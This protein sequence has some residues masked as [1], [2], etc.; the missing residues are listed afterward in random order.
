[1]QLPTEE[2]ESLRDPILVEESE[3]YV[4]IIRLNRP[5]KKNALSNDLVEA[6]V[7][8]VESAREDEAVRV[9][10][11]TGAGDTFFADADPKPR[12]DSG[13][14]EKRTNTD[15]TID[16]SVRLVAG[17]LFLARSPSLPVST[18][19]PLA[20]GE[21]WLCVAICVSL[22]PTLIFILDTLALEPRWIVA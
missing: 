2:Y 6:I 22:A 17:I 3:D 7:W 16:I 10:G 12:K 11:I 14:S 19:L 21:H 15:T 13:P 18:V 5:E 1:M 4:R 8:A 9:I 20:P